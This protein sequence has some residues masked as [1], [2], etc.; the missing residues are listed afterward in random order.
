MKIDKFCEFCKF[1]YFACFMAGPKDALIIEAANFNAFNKKFQLLRKVMAETVKIL[2]N[3]NFYIV[4]WYTKGY[5]R[6]Q[7]LN[8]FT[9]MERCQNIE[10][11][12]EF[13]YVWVRYGLS[14]NGLN[15]PSI[16]LWEVWVRYGLS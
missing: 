1:C 7:S 12:F 3:Q 10:I 9:I 6:Y 8:P 14:S 4:R 11:L 16:E 2:C 5:A 13:W 15:W